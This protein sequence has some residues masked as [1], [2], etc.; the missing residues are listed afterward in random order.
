MVISGEKPQ[1]LTQILHEYIRIM[2]EDK[3]VFPKESFDLVGCA[4][5]VF[6]KLRFG[7]YE[8]YYQEDYALELS[9]LGYK[10]VR[11]FRTDIDYEGT[12]VGKYF[13]DFLV[14]DS[15]IVELKVA[16]DFYL[17]HTKQVLSYLKA[18]NKKLGIILLFTPN[19]VRYKRLVN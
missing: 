13:L 3:I 11:E 15:I 8:K 6:N 7:L 17:N 19:G 2:K 18:T 5:N 16:N 4:Y 12:R 10:F 1:I 9:K 14:N